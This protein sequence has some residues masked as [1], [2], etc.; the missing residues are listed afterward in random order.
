MNKLLGLSLYGTQDGT[1]RANKPK[2]KQI[3][4]LLNFEA[5]FDS[6]GN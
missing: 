1:L 3:N 2:V 4:P 6:S 5:K